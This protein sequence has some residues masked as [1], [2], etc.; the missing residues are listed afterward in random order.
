MKGKMSNQ[1]KQ[2]NKMLVQETVLNPS[3]CKPNWNSECHYASMFDNWREQI[4]QGQ[5]P[6][7]LPESELSLPHDSEG[8]CLFHSDNVEWKEKNNFLQR[9]KVLI[10]LLEADPDMDYIGLDNVV[11]IGDTSTG[12]P[13]TITEYNEDRTLK[14]KYTRKNRNIDLKG[15]VFSKAI[16]VIDAIFLDHVDFTGSTFE[17]RVTFYNITFKWGATFDKAVFKEVAYFNNSIFEYIANFKKTEFGFCSDFE[18]ATSFCQVTFNCKPLFN[19]AVFNGSCSFRETQFDL[20][21][22]R[23]GDTEFRGAVFKNNVDF[24]NTIFNCGVDFQD[25]VFKENCEFIN[26]RFYNKRHLLF[27][28]IQVDG[29]LVFKGNSN[30]KLFKHTVLMEIK[31]EKISGRITFEDAH[32]SY[33]VSEHLH[34]LERLSREKEKKVIIGPGCL[35]YRHTTEPKTIYLDQEHHNL[36]IEIT[37]TFTNYFEIFNGF[38]IG[39]E[40]VEKSDTMIKLVYF[41][42]EDINEKTWFKRLQKTETALWDFLYRSPSQQVIPKNLFNILD[43]NINLLGIFL[44]IGIGIKGGRFKNSKNVEALFDSISFTGVPRFKTDHLPAII[45]K[46]FFDI[47][48]K[49]TGP[50]S[51]QEISIYKQLEERSVPSNARAKKVILFL[52]AN[53]KNAMLLYLDEEFREIE[54][55]LNRSKEREQFKAKALLAV[56]FEDLHRALM[57]Y[58]PYIV[59]FA[60]HGTHEGLTILEDG[61]RYPII[62]RPEVLSRLF[63]H[64]SNQVECVVLSACYSVKQAESIGKYIPYVVGMQRD[65]K[66]EASIEFARGFYR[67]LGAGKTIE[68]AVE[69]GRLAI[70]QNCPEQADHVVTLLK[71]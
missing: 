63:Q 21:R 69:S 61:T 15:Q 29:S 24:Q 59:H 4:R 60:G 56:R 31:P 67:A 20:E 11:F 48:Q 46:N 9:L 71:K 25:V 52:S 12:T 62:L 27:N 64:L 26:T 19:D 6:L 66:D 40:I 1:G 17:E 58:E 32:L 45:Q 10:A 70:R 16:Q 5:F 68:K 8:K 54:E 44:K 2:S 33:I 13:K 49:I 57:E 7:T 14:K 36:I 42:D 35:K 34:Q 53:P 38:N 51:T 39:V 55:A 41:T 23:Q 50:G 37:G 22:R 47:Q 18:P 30:N 65:I 3:S 43:L 28:D